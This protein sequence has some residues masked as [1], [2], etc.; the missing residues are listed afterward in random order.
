MWS[1][2]ISAV[3]SIGGWFASRYLDNKQ[4]ILRYVNYVKEWIENTPTGAEVADDHDD[5]MEGDNRPK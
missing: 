4:R 2:I 3:I 1:A 5:L